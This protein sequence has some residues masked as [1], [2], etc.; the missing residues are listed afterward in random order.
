MIEV[1]IVTHIEAPP[2]ICFDF[3]LSVDL[4]VEST[5]QT[6]ERVVAGRTSGILQDG[7][8]I[9]WE[10][11]HFGIR[12]RLTSRV[13]EYDRPRRFVSRMLKG[14]F[15]QMSHEH[16]FEVSGTGTKMTDR[17]SI[18]APLGPLG[19]IAERVFL[20]TYMRGFLE[21]R[22]RT[23]KFAAEREWKATYPPSTSR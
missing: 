4:H 19:L 10:A 20:R 13:E 6:R 7:E 9:T 23:L 16:L 17:M 18:N 5:A 3:S 2:E 1:V 8:E 22:N 14:A 15:K 12:Q 11:T 21:A